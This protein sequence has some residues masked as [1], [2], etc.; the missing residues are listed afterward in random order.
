M[1]PAQPPLPTA[2][3]FPFQ[4]EDGSQTSILMSESVLGVSVAVTRQKAGSDAYACAAAPRPAPPGGTK[5]PAGT[6]TADVTCPFTSVS[7]ARLS[8][9]APA[10]ATSARPNDARLTSRPAGTLISSAVI[11]HASLV[12]IVSS[13]IPHPLSLIP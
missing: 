7:A 2:W 11:T 1:V 4:P 8:H 9:D 5:P 12:F 13:L 10:A 3:S 6:A